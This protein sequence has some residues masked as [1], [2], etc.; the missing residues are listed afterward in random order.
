MDTIAL[1]VILTLAAA[2][3]LMVLAMVRFSAAI[4]A[5]PEQP[6]AVKGWRLIYFAAWGAIVVVMVQ[7]AIGADAMWP[8]AA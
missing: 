4:V 2:S 5:E 7:G 3:I 1:A 8:Q 6:S